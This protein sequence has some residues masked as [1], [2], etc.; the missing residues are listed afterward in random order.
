M[1]T[2]VFCQYADCGFMYVETD[3]MPP[4]IC[5]WCKKTA[6]WSDVPRIDDPTVPRVHYRLNHNDKRFLKGIHVTPE[7]DT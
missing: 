1:A 4:L 6:R 7:E 3:G 5:P 2:E